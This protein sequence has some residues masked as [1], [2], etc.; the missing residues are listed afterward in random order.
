[1]QCCKTLNTDGIFP[2]TSTKSVKIQ[3]RHS[4]LTLI[5]YLLRLFDLVRTATG[6]KIS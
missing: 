3:K 2:E 5:G 1:M 6:Y 4:K